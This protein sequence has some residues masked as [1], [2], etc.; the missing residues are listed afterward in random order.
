MNEINWK[1]LSGKYLHRDPW[2]TV[3]QDCLELPDGRIIPNYYILEYP[4]WVNV[5]AVTPDQQLIMERQYR[6]GLGAY[7]FELCA[8]TVEKTDASVLEAARRELLEETGFGGGKWSE[9]LVLSPNPSSHNNLAHTFLA[10]NVVH[11]QQPHLDASEDIQVFLMPEDEVFT[12]LEQGKIVSGPMVAA[13]W[14]YRLFRRENRF[15]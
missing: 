1:T 7:A 11:M 13:L 10:R 9:F 14:K 8:G 3:R 12:L 2:L 15:S 4:E 6:P 5:I